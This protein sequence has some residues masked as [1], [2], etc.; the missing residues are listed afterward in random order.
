MKNNIWKL[1]QKLQ[2]DKLYKSISFKHH[3]QEKAAN[4][5]VEYDIS[6]QKYLK[7]RKFR[8]E[9]NKLKPNSGT[10]TSNN[11]KENDNWPY[12]NLK[13]KPENIFHMRRPRLIYLSIST[14]TQYRIKW[15]ITST[16]FH[17]YPHLLSTVSRIA[18]ENIIL[19]RLQWW[20]HSRFHPYP[21]SWRNHTN[22]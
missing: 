19:I 22:A 9:K 3:N 16:S 4:K 21:T 14:E 17:C 12:E 6:K 15:S 5:Q 10:N 2:K 20:R 18:I 11:Q 13:M 8:L 1:T 7:L